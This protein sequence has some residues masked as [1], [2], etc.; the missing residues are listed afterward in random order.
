MSQICYRSLN[1]S[2]A[3]TAAALFRIIDSVQGTLTI[4]EA[5]FKDS[6]VESQVAKILNHGYT[7]GVAI[8]RLNNVSEPQAYQAFGPKIIASRNPF[9]DAALESRCLDMR[10]T[11]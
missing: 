1:V 4:D 11:P 10:M 7:R 5:D 9:K 8:I 6:W 3:I 2:G